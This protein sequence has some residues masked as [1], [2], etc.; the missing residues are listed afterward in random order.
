M[1]WGLEGLKTCLVN[2]G[3]GAN[4]LDRLSGADKIRISEII[5]GDLKETFALTFPQLEEVYLHSKP[6]DIVQ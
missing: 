3:N 4:T 1:D 5:S 2:P 6:I